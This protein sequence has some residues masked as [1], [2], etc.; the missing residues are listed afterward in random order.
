MLPIAFVNWYPCLY[1][2]GRPDPFGFPEWLQFC[3]PLAAALVV[4][5][6]LLVWRTGVRRYTS[7]GS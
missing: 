6:A 4:A 1:L 3:S 5:A 2:L 7:T